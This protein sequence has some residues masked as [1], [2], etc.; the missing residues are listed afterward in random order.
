MGVPTRGLLNY[1]QIEWLYEELDLQNRLID[2]RE[3]GFG[4]RLVDATLS[5]LSDLQTQRLICVERV[6]RL[7]NQ[8]QATMKLL[9][10]WLHLNMDCL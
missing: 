8:A 3:A 2:V 1:P 4:K 7:K 5:D 6:S 9:N 10:E